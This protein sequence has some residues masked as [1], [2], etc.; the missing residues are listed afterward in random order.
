MSIFTNKQ[1]VV[2]VLVA[3]ILAIGAWYLVGLIGAETPQ[4]A[5]EGNKYP[6]VAK[7]NCRYESG[8]CSLENG[9][10]E[11]ELYLAPA[12]G[13][14]RLWVRANKLAQ[15]V[16]VALGSGGAVPDPKAMQFEPS[17][18]AWFLDLPQV[19]SES[20][21]YLVAQV[22]GSTYFAETTTRF[23]TRLDSIPTGRD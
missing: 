14:S 20:D 13:K 17:E 22:Q 16:L 3:P 19:D 10:L 18:R 23:F 1:V 12:K 8:L 21:L 5:V 6:L 7:S 4:A 9:E 2:A 15:G 11:F